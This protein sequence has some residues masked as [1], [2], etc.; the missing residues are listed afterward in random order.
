VSTVDAA[1]VRSLLRAQ[2]PEIHAAQV[3]YL[4]EGCDSIAFEV[5][6]SLVFRFP[7]RADVEAQIAGERTVLNALAS[8]NPPLAVPRIR[9]EGRPTEAFPFRFAGYPK[10][11]GDPAI[12]KAWSGDQLEQIAPALGRFLGWLHG[13]ALESTAGAGLEAQDM[14]A[15]VGDMRQ[16]ALEEFPKVANVAPQA[17]LEHWRSWLEAADVGDHNDDSIVL[18]HNDFAAEHVL[19]DESGSPTGVID[20][21]DVALGDRAADFAGIYHW[22]GRALVTAVV[23]AYDGPLRAGQ[24]RRA[25]FL[26]ACRGV[27]DVSFGLEHRRPEYIQ[28]GLRA[29]TLNAGT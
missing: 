19:V 21:S 17:S 25:Q 14:A 20:W 3:E 15:F 12:R 18:L 22:G 23:S 27:L 1:L 29:L 11:P 4:N 24:H 26:A 6:G 16:E 8:A 5:N 28:A 7:K 10:I 13:I 9:Y 2:F